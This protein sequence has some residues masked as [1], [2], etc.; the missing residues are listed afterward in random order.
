MIYAFYIFAFIA[1]ASAA[2]ILFTRRLFHAALLLLVC[3]LGVAGI[4]A[5]SFAEWVAVTQILVYAGGVVVII[6]FGIMLTARITG[7][8]TAVASSRWFS[9]T[10]LGLAAMGFLVTLYLRGAF[11]L[12]VMPMSDAQFTMVNRFGIE[13][14]TDYMLPFEVAGLLLLITLI[15]AAVI[16]ATQNKNSIS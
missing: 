10:L 13:L 11:G 3:F 7:R 8:P 6:I 14:M 16:A 2:G 1:V 9:G 12:G 5:V 15:G 4:Y